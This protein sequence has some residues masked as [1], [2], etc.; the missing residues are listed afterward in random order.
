MNPL[1]SPHILQAHLNA[2]F[3]LK[4]KKELVG[5]VGFTVGRE[6]PRKICLII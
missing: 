1:A 5:K 3:S 4:K 6:I 2:Q